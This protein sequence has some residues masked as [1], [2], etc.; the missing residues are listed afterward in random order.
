MVPGFLTK[1]L[2]AFAPAATKEGAH[3]GRPY[4][5]AKIGRMSK[6]ATA[7]LKFLLIAQFFGAFNDNAWKLIVTFLA[8]KASTAHLAPGGPEY[9]SAA[10]LQTAIAFCVLTI[11]LM[12]FSLPAGLLADRVSKRTVIVSMKVAEVLLMGSAALALYTAPGSTLAPLVI[13]GLMGLQSALF[14]PAKYGI[15]PEML[16]HQRLTAGNAHLETWT[17]LAIILGTASGGLL[18][19]LSGEVAWTAAAVLVPAAVVGFLIS[20]RIPRVPAARSEGNLGETVRTAWRAIRRERVLRLAVAGSV[21]YWTIASLLGQDILVY[22]KSVLGLSDTHAGIPL[23]LFGL[24]VGGGSLITARLSRGKV[25]Y[26]VIPLGAI[27]MAGNTLLLALVVPGFYGLL[28]F[29]AALGVASGMIIVPLNSLLQWRAPDRHRGAVIALANVWIFGGITLGSLGAAGLAALGL[30]PVSILVVAALALTAGMCWAVSLLPDVLLRLLLVLATHSLYRLRVVG[31]ERVPEQG[32]ALL[33]PNHVSFIDFV[34]LLAVIDRPIRFIV[35][36]KYYERF[37]FKPFMKSLGCIPISSSEGPREILRALRDAGERLDQGELVCIFPEGQISRT[38]TMLPFNRGLERILRNRRAPIIP[39]YLDRIWGSIFSYERDRFVLKIPREIPYQVTLAFGAPMP[40]GTDAGTIRQAVQEL[41]CAAWTH[42]QEGARPLHRAFVRRARTR[43]LALA[44]ADE[45]RP[46]LN[47]IKALTGAVALAR[48]LKPEWAGQERV[49]ILLPPT[50][51][52]AL[53]NLA[54][55]LACRVT[56]NLNYTAGVHGMESAVEQAGLETVVTSRTFLKKADLTPPGNVRLLYLEELAEGIGAGLRVSSLLAALFSPCRRLEKLCGA[57]RVPGPRDLATIIFS[58][59]STGDPKGVMLT[60]FNLDSNIDAAE[61]VLRTRTAD[62]I[63]GIMPM[64]H[65]FGY[66]VFWFAAKQGL[67]LPM[68]PNPLDGP[69]VGRLVERYRVSIMLTA[70][71]FLRIYLRLCTP[72]QFGSLRLVVTGA[73]KLPERLASA[74]QDQFGLRPLEGYGTTECSPVVSVG[75]PDYR[76][77][78]FFQ[79]GSRPGTVGQPLPGVAVR[80]VDPDTF[81]PLPAGSPGMLLVKGPNLMRGYL[82]RDDLTRKAIRNGWYVTGD[83]GL[84]SEDGFVKITDR[85]ARFSKI[86]GEMVPHGR[87]EELLHQAAE[88]EEQVFAVTGIP[89]EKKGEALAVL[90]TLD[91]SRIGPVLGRLAGLGLPNLHTPRRDRFVKTEQIPLLGTGKL[92]LRA[93]RRL[94]RRKLERRSNR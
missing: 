80:V 42:R 38:G 63:L 81:D 92:D 54:S 9:Q 68:H 19:D 87:V 88:S 76:A 89:D 77:P 40:S 48:T 3:K 39:V 34:L 4:P 8:I 10:Q 75:V 74:F 16:P 25:E 13:L 32:G 79:S 30:S 41:S 66:M 71:T 65:S 23:A 18:L 52:S 45:S 49:G 86:G 60:Q 33:V 7:G 84:V 22:V 59:G 24:G 67:A 12:I 26:G 44:Y 90:H 35:H 20:L 83:I 28:A 72:G 78:G 82:G 57:T 29:S 53:M 55:A 85:L 37:Y 6:D 1:G 46:R 15:L 50:V 14:S 43:P 47:R 62:R 36:R 94:A 64:F 61:Q 5:N 21:V 73:E 56:V 91:E 70:P 93:V 27:L 17:F 2:V 51:A 69:A 11:P 31:R 58:S